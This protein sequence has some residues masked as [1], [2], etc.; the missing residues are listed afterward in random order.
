MSNNEKTL[1]ITESHLEDV[2]A[3]TVC[4]STL[5]VAVESLRDHRHVMGVPCDDLV[6]SFDEWMDKVRSKVTESIEGLADEH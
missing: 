3:A 2:L 1:R 4:V 6:A 5:A